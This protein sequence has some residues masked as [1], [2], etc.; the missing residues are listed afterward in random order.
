LKIQDY[1]KYI[2]KYSKKVFQWAKN[3]TKA[4]IVKFMYASFIEPVNTMKNLKVPKKM[5]G[6]NYKMFY[7]WNQLQYNKEELLQNLAYLLDIT[8]ENMN[9]ESIQLEVKQLKQK[10]IAY[11]SNA[12]LSYFYDMFK[13]INT[14]RNNLYQTK[15]EDNNIIPYKFL[16]VARIRKQMLLEKEIKKEFEKKS[17]KKEINKKCDKQ[18]FNEM[19]ESFKE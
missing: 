8:N 13:V 10:I 18:L 2:K 4:K 19:I 14:N 1:Q 9:Y 15:Y 12:Y 11:D 16:L 7:F 17:I 6:D 3:K 5:D